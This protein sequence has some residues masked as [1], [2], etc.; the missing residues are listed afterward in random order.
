MQS[1]FSGP[2]GFPGA[3]PRGDFNL[4]DSFRCVLE[5]EVKRV[6]FCV[7]GQVAE[8]AYGMPPHFIEFIFGINLLVKISKHFS[9]S[10]YNSLDSRNSASEYHF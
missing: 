5:Y 8:L 10:N 4:L 1:I 6:L 7:Y 2:C 9:A 3:R